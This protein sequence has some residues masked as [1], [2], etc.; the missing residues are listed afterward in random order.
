VEWQREEKARIRFFS[1]SL[2]LFSDFARA[3]AKNAQAAA[4]RLRNLEI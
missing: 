3:S 2:A 4:V 1:H